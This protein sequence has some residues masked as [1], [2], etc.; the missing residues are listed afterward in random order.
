VPVLL[1]KLPTDLRLILGREIKD[2]QWSLTQIMTLL[3]QEIETR[4]RC[5]GVIAISPSKRNIIIMLVLRASTL[6]L[7]LRCLHGK[8]MYQLVP[9]VEKAM[10]LLSVTSLQTSQLGKKYFENRDGVL[11]A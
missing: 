6:R 4:E 9:I 1:S 5:G 10:P 7:H 8:R 3:R 2:E 11:F